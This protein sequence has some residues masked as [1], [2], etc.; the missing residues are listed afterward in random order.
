MA[1]EKS[2]QNEGKEWH[3][4]R[5]RSS[6]KWKVDEEVTTNVTEKEENDPK[7]LQIP[8]PCLGVLLLLFRHHPAVATAAGH[9]ILL[10]GQIFIKAAFTNIY[11]Q[12]Y[13]ATHTPGTIFGTTHFKA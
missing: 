4:M 12:T 7:H 3:E 9:V 1:G 11:T 6:T 13:V 8:V 10:L 2:L 5:V